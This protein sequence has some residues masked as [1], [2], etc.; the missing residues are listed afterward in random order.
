LGFV[1]IGAEA[2]YLTSGAL[3]G[4]RLSLAF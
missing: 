2:G 4:G 3:I 1:R